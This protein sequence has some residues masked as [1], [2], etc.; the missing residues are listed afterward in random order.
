MVLRIGDGGA[1]TATATVAQ[2][3][4]G[5]TFTNNQTFTDSD[6]TLGDFSY[7][8]TVASVRYIRVTRTAGTV[9]RDAITYSTN[10]TTCPLIAD[11]SITKAVNMT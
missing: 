3:L 10:V 1:G 9:N 8:T 5:T 4:D 2:S 11:L 7:T 6:N